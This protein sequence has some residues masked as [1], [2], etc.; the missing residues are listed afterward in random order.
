MN[1]IY[2]CEPVNKVS[3]LVTSQTGCSDGNLSNEQLREN[4]V[5]M[6]KKITC[7]LK[8]LPKKSPKRKRLGLELYD[9]N[10][11]IHRIRPKKKAPGV[12]IYFISAAKDFLTM[13]TFNMIMDNAVTMMKK[14]GDLNE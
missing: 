4:L 8:L 3:S 13:S 5:K 2:E 11:Q 6:A 10:H 9:L 7:D 12:E 14:N 1:R